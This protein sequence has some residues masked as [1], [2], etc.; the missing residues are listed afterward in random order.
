[1]GFQAESSVSSQ[2]IKMEKDGNSTVTNHFRD[3]WPGQQMV[4]G[5]PSVQGE[6]T[7]A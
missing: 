7:T 3:L 1:M 2:L 5:V 4:F 6:Y